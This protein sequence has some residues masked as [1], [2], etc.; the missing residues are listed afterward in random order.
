MKRKNIPLNALRAFEAAARLGRL[1]VAAEE[2]GVTHGA[3][4]RQVSLLEDWLGATL[5]QRGASQ[6][7]LTDNG[8]V[9]AQEVTSLLDRLSVVTAQVIEKALTTSRPRTRY[10]VGTDAMIGARV[11]AKLPDRLRD[12]FLS[13]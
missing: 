9:Y 12:R 5:F 4:S 11:I 1:T 13:R 6:V 3:V 7:A 8:R 10:T 2:L